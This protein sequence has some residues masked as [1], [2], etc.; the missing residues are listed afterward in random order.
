MLTL[1]LLLAA[2]AAVGAGAAWLGGK[3]GVAKRSAGP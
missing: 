3:L 2:I 1:G